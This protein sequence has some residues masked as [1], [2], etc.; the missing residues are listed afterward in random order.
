VL[1]ANRDQLRRIPGE[2]Q[3]GDPKFVILQLGHLVANELPVTRKLPYSYPGVLTELKKTSKGLKRE[4][5][6]KFPAYSFILSYSEQH[7]KKI[8]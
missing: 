2:T 5:S 8:V 7:S 3:A 4:D 1:V 6:F